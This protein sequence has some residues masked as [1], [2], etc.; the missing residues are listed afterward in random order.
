MRVLRQLAQQYS[1]YLQ[2]TAQCYYRDSSV[3][4]SST[5]GQH[6]TPPPAASTTTNP[7]AV[8][9]QKCIQP[10]RLSGTGEQ[11]TLSVVSL[12]RTPPATAQIVRPLP[13]SP[14]TPSL[15]ILRTAHNSLISKLFLVPQQ[16]RRLHIAPELKT[17]RLFGRQ[18]KTN[19]K[20]VSLRVSYAQPYLLF[21]TNPHCAAQPKRDAPCHNNRFFRTPRLYSPSP[22]LTP[23][24]L[25]PSPLFF[26][27]M[28]G[29]ELV[30]EEAGR[31]EEQQ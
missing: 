8:G 30:P 11:S 3:S 24:Q 5:Q 4:Q 16:R 25:L 22:F 20:K 13:A 9:P 26:S 27:H 1:P 17:R 18:K 29:D 31:E 12:D 2:T 7:G 19:K 28:L 10:V 21:L 6:I 23:L 14:P 15:S